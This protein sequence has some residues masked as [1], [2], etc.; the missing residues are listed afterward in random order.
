ML[1]RLSGAKFW[2]LGWITFGIYRIVAWCRMTNNLNAM[3]YQLGETPIRGY[4]G[5]MLLGCVTFGIYPLV[6]FFKFFGLATRLSEKTN[7]GITPCGTFG[8]FLMTWIP[9]YSFFWVAKMNNRLID[10]YE[11]K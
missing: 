10:A 4:F 1:K 8:K 7:A 6:W 11:D 3:A 9:I 5:A 2:L